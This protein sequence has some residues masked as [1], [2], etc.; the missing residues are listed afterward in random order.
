MD[1]SLHTNLV[2]FDGECNL[3]N[4][5]VQFLI[6]QDKKQLL[7]F[8]TLQ[9]ADRKFQNQK[10]TDINTIKRKSNTP[11][12]V[13]YIRKGQQYMR[14]NAVLYILKDLG[15][16][17]LFTQIFWLVP[18][19]WRDVIYEWVG[20]NRYKWFG[21]KTSCMMPTP[22]LQSMQHHQTDYR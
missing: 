19:S 12:S 1:T 21:K 7:R 15:G 3:C 20:R 11:T 9:R 17:W 4:G 14:S 13:V 2:L 10:S 6:R 16:I 18:R 22:E 8:G 5:F